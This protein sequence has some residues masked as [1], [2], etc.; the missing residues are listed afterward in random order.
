MA[1]LY[2]LASMSTATTGTG[3]ITLGSAVSGALSFAAAGVQDGDTVTY[4][5]K[6]GANSEIGRGVYTASG[7]TLTRSVLK[8]TNSNTAISLSGAAEVFITA[9]AE[10]IADTAHQPRARWR[11]WI[12]QTTTT[13]GNLSQLVQATFYDRSATLIDVKNLG[14][15]LDGGAYGGYPATNLFDQIGASTWASP[16]APP[17]WFGFYMPGDVDV[18]SFTLKCYSVQP[19]RV[20]SEIELQWSR[21]PGRRWHTYQ[22]WGPLTWTSGETKTFTCNADD[23]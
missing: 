22:S 12:S 8:S 14:T 11:V 23:T 18:G 16:G 17:A 7:T 5:I 20:P 6:D 13:P 3:T 9:A 21:G 10:D 15:V 4:A 1:K 2:N 19:D